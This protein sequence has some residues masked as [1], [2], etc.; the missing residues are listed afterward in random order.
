MKRALFIALLTCVALS[1]AASAQVVGTAH[2]LSST[3]SDGS[4]QVCVFCHTPHSSNDGPA[5]NDAAI[6]VGNAPLWN[7]DIDDAVNDYGAYDSPTMDATAANVTRAV[8]SSSL[9][10]L[11]CHDGSVAPG[12]FYNNPNGATGD[13]TSTAVAI[14]GS[15]LVGLSIADDHPVSFLYATASATDLGLVTPEPTA[16]TVAGSV[17]CASCHDPHDRAAV[18]DPNVDF[19]RDTLQGSALCL[20]CHIK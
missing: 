5:G 17:E 10:C 12:S 6:L 7:Q 18:T 16:F 1:S 19:M 9:L 8:Y 11:S 14:T 4:L 13:S 15:A 2:D 20:N 3:L